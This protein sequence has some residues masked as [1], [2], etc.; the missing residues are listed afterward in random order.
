MHGIQLIRSRGTFALNEKNASIGKKEFIIDQLKVDEFEYDDT[1]FKTSS[2]PLTDSTHVK[3][4][5]VTP[6][7]EY[8]WPIKK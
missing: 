5:R 4:R 8:T 6:P 3:D 1:L 2:L 7:S